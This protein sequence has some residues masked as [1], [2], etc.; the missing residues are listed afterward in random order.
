MVLPLQNIV[1]VTEV[2]C[3]FLIRL[4][5]RFGRCSRILDPVDAT[6]DILV[7]PRLQEHGDRQLVRAK[8]HQ[9]DLEEILFLLA[10]CTRL[11]LDHRFNAQLETPEAHSDLL[12]VDE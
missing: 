1:Q 2:L 9:E 6:F 11:C 3:V 12:K 5:K 7:G 4:Q 8:Q 10:P